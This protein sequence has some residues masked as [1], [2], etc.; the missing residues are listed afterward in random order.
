MNY[1]IADTHFGHENV[2]LLDSRPFVTV[3]EM[4]REMIERWNEKVQ[5]AD[6]VYILGDFCYMSERLEQWYLRQLK[7]H[8]HLIIGNHDRALLR[9]EEAMAFFESVEKIQYVI[10]GDKRLILCH[11][12]LCEWNGFHAGI[13]HIYGHIHG[14]RDD[15]YLFMRQRERALNAGCMINSYVPV[16]LSELIDN[17]RVFQGGKS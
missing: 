12:P 2:I 13:W 7:G 9:N 3:D 4:D 16:S 17:N 15:T 8:K 1:Y 14:K 6:D 10:D 11:Y 5:D